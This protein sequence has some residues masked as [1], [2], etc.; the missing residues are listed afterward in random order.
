MKRCDNC[1]AEHRKNKIS[2]NS[3]RIIIPEK[4]GIG[5][6]ET[7]IVK[8]KKLHSNDPEIQKA[9]DEYLKKGGVVQV[10]SPQKE[11]TS[12][13]QGLVEELNDYVSSDL[14]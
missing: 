3:S 11:P 13:Y 6:E 10:V 5:I 4:L 7:K 1:R 9:L 14:I 12:L 2:E 8:P